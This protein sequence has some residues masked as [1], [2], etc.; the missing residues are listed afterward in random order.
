M[1]QRWNLLRD[2]LLL[3]TQVTYIPCPKRWASPA[4]RLPQAMR[5]LPVLGAV[6]GGLLFGLLHLL[7]VVPPISAAVLL[8][9]MELVLGGAHTMRRLMRV[10]D[11]RAYFTEPEETVTPAK[12]GC[13]AERKQHHFKAGPNGLLWGLLRSVVLFCVFYLLMRH[14]QLGQCAVLCAAV[15]CRWL[16]VW[17]V[18]YFPAKPPARFRHAMDRRAMVRV[19]CFTLAVILCFSRVPL[20]CG[21][22]FAF[23]GVYLF[24]KLRVR[25]YGTL[26]ESCY[27]AAC[28][29]AE[30]LFLL[31]WLSAA[32][33]WI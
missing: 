27:G 25:T 15:V 10:V 33:V 18:W 31:S 6:L 17:M 7:V 16:T 14:P 20:L 1:K 23:V 13:E 2:L 19:S 9:G 28:A 26:D 5:L 29:W 30:L 4:E 12:P 24:G 32:S 22:V 8:V 11:G 21:V 3:V